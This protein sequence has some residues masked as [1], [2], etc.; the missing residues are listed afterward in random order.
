MPA[1]IYRLKRSTIALFDQDGRH[2]ARRL[3]EGAVIS[4]EGMEE[5]DLV[6]VTWEEKKIRM[7]AQDIRERAEKVHKTSK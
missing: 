6:E 2:V 3:P 7:Y 5:K 1:V 4:V